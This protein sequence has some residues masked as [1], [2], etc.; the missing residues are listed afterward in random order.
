[1]SL[2]TETDNGKYRKNPI[3]IDA[4]L[5]NILYDYSHVIYGNPQ[6]FVDIVM[7][8]LE[9]YKDLTPKQVKHY[10][11]KVAT[12]AS[13]ML[14]NNPPVS[15]TTPEERL[16]VAR[17]RAH[18]D[19]LDKVMSA[20]RD[21]VS[22]LK[23][24]E[25]IGMTSPNGDVRYHFNSPTY[26]GTLRTIIREHKPIGEPFVPQNVLYLSLVYA[27]AKQHGRDFDPNV[28]LD[29]IESDDYAERTISMIKTNY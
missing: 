5:M 11:R 20:I 16:F 2:D 25:S 17:A 18:K 9:E 29:L 23:S 27:W 15:T 14:G 7:D 26:A 13:D 3:E 28:V 19:R 10:R 6:R 8:A 12:Y 4:A 1:M 22:D 21:S 24:L